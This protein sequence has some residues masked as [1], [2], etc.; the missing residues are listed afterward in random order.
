MIVD[1]HHLIYFKKDD[2]RYYICSKSAIKAL[3]HHSL[4]VLWWLYCWHWSCISLRGY[5]GTAYT[6]IAQYHG[7]FLLN[8]P[9]FS[10]YLFLEK[11]S[12][13]HLSVNATEKSCQSGSYIC[14][15]LFQTW[16][17]YFLVGI[18]LTE[19]ENIFLRSLNKWT[20]Q[21]GTNLKTLNIEKIYH[22]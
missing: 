16:K 13:R 2:H 15:K 10:K 19:C 21:N 8:F 5:H 3:G 22:L 6:E 18:E 14:S 1:Y 9:K 4:I 17:M 12:G 11:P 20:K 7:R